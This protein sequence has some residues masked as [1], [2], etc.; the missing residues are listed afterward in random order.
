MS[1]NLELREAATGF[2]RTYSRVDVCGEIIEAQVG[3]VD[4]YRWF[5]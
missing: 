4:C 3:T 2:L 5:L 1:L